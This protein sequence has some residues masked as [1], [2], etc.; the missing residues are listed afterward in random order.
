MSCNSI[1]KHTN[2]T[3]NSEL[4]KESLQ[5]SISCADSSSIPM[6]VVKGNENANCL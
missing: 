6:V 5:S 2:P 4:H 3:Q 1:E